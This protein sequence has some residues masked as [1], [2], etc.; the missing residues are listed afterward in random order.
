MHSHARARTNAAHLLLHLAL[1]VVALTLVAC[2]GGGG[3]PG[4]CHGGPEVC[5]GSG[6]SAISGG[7]S[8]GLTQVFSMSGTGDSV[9]KLPATVTRVQI[10]ASYNGVSQ[11]FIVKI[12]GSLVVNEIVGSSR[13]PAAFAGTFLVAGG[14]VVEITNSTGVNWQVTE[15]KADAPATT[16]FF[17]RSGTGPAVFDIPSTATRLRVRAAYA[18][19]AENFA[20]KVAG[21]LLVNQ[22]LG[23]AQNLTSFDVTYSIPSGGAVEILEANGVSWSVQQIQ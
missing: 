2:G 3:N 6:G 5:A 18:G 4:E 15:V 14:S 12:G 1:A 10:Q 19:I 16:G 21:V 23:S 8:G 9:F 11:N 17:A 13:T 20:V 7:T 22:I